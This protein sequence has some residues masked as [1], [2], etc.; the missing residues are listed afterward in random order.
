VRNCAL[1]SI[2]GMRVLKEEERIMDHMLGLMKEHGGKLPER[3][4]EEPRGEPLKPIVLEDPRKKITDAT[5]LP[6]W[7]LPTVSI[8]QV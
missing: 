1:K 2:D 5:F 6:G 7:N 8:E 4:K 3:P